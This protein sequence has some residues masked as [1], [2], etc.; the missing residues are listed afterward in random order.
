[1]ITTDTPTSN[2]TRCFVTLKISKEFVKNERLAELFDERTYCDEFIKSLIFSIEKR[3]LELFG[4]VILSNQIHL[5][6]QPCG[7]KVIETI[8]ELKEL[9]AKA[10]L[11]LMGK[12]LNSTDRDNCCKQSDFRKIFHNYINVDEAMFWQKTE[13]PVELKIKDENVLPIRSETLSFYLE[14]S[15]RSYLHLGANAFTK[16]MLDTMKI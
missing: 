12:N 3:Q 14:K 2:K 6:I 4:F 13:R 11:Q 5:I 16:L 1:M 9:S 8:D 7:E 15:D 10:V